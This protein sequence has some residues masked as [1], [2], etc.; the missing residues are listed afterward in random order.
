MMEDLSTGPPR[1]GA[2]RR[3][4]IGISVKFV[5]PTTFKAND[6][7]GSENWRSW[8]IKDPDIGIEQDLGR[9]GSKGLLRM[10]LARSK[11][12]DGCGLMR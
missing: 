12:L 4:G 7:T 5:V 2:E 8:K 3:R 9:Q 6:V 10:L 11:D 1:A